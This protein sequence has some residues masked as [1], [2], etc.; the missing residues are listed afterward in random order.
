[1]RKVLTQ[2]LRKASGNRKPGY[3]QD[4]LACSKVNSDIFVVVSEE[5]FV[6]IRK[7]YRLNGVGDCLH[8]LLSCFGFKVNAGCKCNSHMETMNKWGPDTCSENIETIVSWLK[9]EAVRRKMPFFNT[10]GRMLVRRAIHNARKEASR[11]AEV[12]VSD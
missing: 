9:A 3:L 6:R 1:L 8:E 5:D 2:T 11:A 12:R 7:Q 4:V 10:V